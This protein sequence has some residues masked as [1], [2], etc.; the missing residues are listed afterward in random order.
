[1]RASPVPLYIQI[2]EELRGLIR[3]GQLGPMAKVLSEAE[4][5]SRFRVSRMTA[6]KALDRLVADGVLFRQPGKGT[7]VAQAKIPHGASQRLSFSAAMRSLGLPTATRVLE[8]GQ[9]P[10]PSNIALAIGVPPASTVVF[11]RRLRSVDAEPAA[12]HMSYLP[13]RFSAILD[14]DLTGSLFDLMSALGGRVEHSRDMLEAVTA[15][16]E[17]AALLGLPQGAPL[18]FIH[19]TAFASS[20]EPLRYSESLYRGDRFRFSVDDT[21]ALDM[22]L[23]VKQP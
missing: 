2:E 9:V 15:T 19:G 18:I 14:R 1:M 22:R 20:G 10:A 3:S 13:P 5:S 7:F 11:L 17:D 23:E 21:G 4:L 8:S 16:S 12:I 6:R